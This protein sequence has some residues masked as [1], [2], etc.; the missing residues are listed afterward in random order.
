MLLTALC[1]H[2]YYLASVHPFDGILIIMRWINVEIVDMIIPSI[3]GLTIFHYCKTNRP[4]SF[5]KWDGT[6]VA[7]HRELSCRYVTG[8]DY[9]TAL[10]LSVFMG[11]F[12]IDR[13]YLGY[14]F[15][16]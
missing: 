4:C 14:V 10:I 3:S 11:M 9:R 7:Y 16:Q 5:Q 8:Y 1:N 13:F 2:K 6:E 12:G 15:T